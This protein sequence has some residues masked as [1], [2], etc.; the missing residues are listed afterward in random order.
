MT[1]LFVSQAYTT[2]GALTRSEHLHAFIT[3]L[4]NKFTGKRFRLCS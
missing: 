3:C 2:F 1:R 4:P